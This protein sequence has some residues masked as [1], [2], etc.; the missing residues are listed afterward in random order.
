MANSAIFRLMTLKINKILL[1]IMLCALC[2]LGAVEVFASL[3]G[4]TVY[5]QA[6]VWSESGDPWYQ[7]YCWGPNN[8]KAW[9]TMENV[10]GFIYK[11]TIPS[12]NYNGMKFLRTQPGKPARDWN[13]VWNQTGDQMESDIGDN[14]K[15]DIEGW[16]YGTWY[17]HSVVPKDTYIYFENEKTQWENVWM[18]IVCGN[19]NKNATMSSYK[20]KE[21]CVWLKM[22]KYCGT[23]YRVKLD[24]DA[25][26]GLFTFADKNLSLYEHI[27]AASIVRHYGLSADY[28][29]VNPYE[30]TYVE[31]ESGLEIKSYDWSGNIQAKPGRWI[32][33]DPWSMIS[34]SPSVKNPV[35]RGTS[36]TLTTET[37]TP[38]WM[39]FKSTN[40]RSWVTTT[41]G[42]SG[43]KSEN[44]TD[45]P[46]ASMY[47][48]V[49]DIDNMC[50]AT[51]RVEIDIEC[52]GDKKTLL[53]LN[54]DTNASGAYFTNEQ[55]RREVI[56]S[57]GEHI[58]T[59]I[60]DY[61]EQGKEILDGF[62]AILANPVYGGRGMQKTPYTC[63]SRSCL[64]NA[65]TLATDH[66]WYVN[67]KDHTHGGSN[68]GKIGGMLMANC[69]EKNEIIFSYTTDVL[70]GR[71]LFMTFSAWFA[72]ATSPTLNTDLGLNN[73]IIPINAKIRILSEN[74][75]DTIAHIDVKNV[76]PNATHSLA[77]QEGRSSFFSGDNDRLYVEIV[78][79]GESGTGNDIL[80]DDIKFTACVP[81]VEAEPTTDVDCGEETTLTVDPEG[82]AEIFDGT[83]YYLWQRWNYT[84]S[85]WVSIADATEPG[86][87]GAGNETYTF[88]TE[89]TPPDHKPKFRVIMSNS[90]DVAHQV[91][92]G[93]PP[94][95]VNFAIT[96]DILVD[97]AC[98]PQTISKTSGNATQTVCEGNSISSVVYTSGGTANKNAAAKWLPEGLTAAKS[99][100]TLTISGT[101][102]VID[103]DS[104]YTIKVFAEGTEGVSCPS[105]TLELVINSKRKPSLTLRDGDFKDQFICKKTNNAEVDSE[106]DYIVDDIQYTWG[107]SA[108][109]VQITQTPTPTASQA[110]LDVEKVAA[111]K[112]ITLSGSPARTTTYTVRT[113]GQ[114]SVCAAAVMSG[115]ITVGD[116]PAEPPL[117]YRQIQ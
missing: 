55:Q 65:S 67:L 52:D 25:F 109:D 72:N 90:R 106:N 85:K 114:N 7:I 108:T 61:S 11:A 84:T 23:I 93:N 33:D 78:N 9:V 79:Y 17:K 14:N 101:L 29:C 104:T 71:N 73:A 63:H 82:V 81:R 28:P 15:F 58:N 26:Y 53:D 60:Y 20:P 45:A 105:D 56:A 95:C 50:S 19:I 112:T 77:W 48:H 107:G 22:E 57:K 117:R 8:A 46:T 42:I 34:I 92:D 51:Y 89:D 54:F 30:R 83:P 66:A 2:L 70:C 80:I 100:K 99:G 39:W 49:R 113:T 75:R 5:L 116:I 110:G 18:S 44:L 91:G 103:K 111:D 38:T 62:Y 87:S 32:S 94:D 37:S 97:C 74:K 59:A 96:E 86:G 68:D 3:G 35:H 12:G 10:T 31:R 41:S 36:V 98:V 24:R 43:S 76:R 88:A 13:Y 4:K 1:K 40:G 6:G 16:S 69:K 102:P 47:Y 115:T 27:Y 21:D 64:S